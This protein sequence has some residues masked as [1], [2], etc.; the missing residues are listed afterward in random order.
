[1]DFTLLLYVLAKITFGFNTIS[2]MFYRSCICVER[3]VST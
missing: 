2:F 3:I 1:M